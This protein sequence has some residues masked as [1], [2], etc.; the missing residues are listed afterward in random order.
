MRSRVWSWDANVATLSKKYLPSN[1]PHRPNTCPPRPM[2]P[3][4]NSVDDL[5]HHN[6]SAA[7]TIGNLPKNQKTVVRAS[8][9]QLRQP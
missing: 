5:N 6:R 4:L 3:P 7:P 2:R 1:L 9:R 8:P